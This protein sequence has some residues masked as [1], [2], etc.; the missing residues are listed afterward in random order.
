MGR[1]LR[2]A[3]KASQQTG[4]FDFSQWRFVSDLNA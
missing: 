1:I 4:T 2:T 3:Q